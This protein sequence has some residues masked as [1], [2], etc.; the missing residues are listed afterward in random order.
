MRGGG[1]VVRGCVMLSAQAP[2]SAAGFSSCQAIWAFLFVLLAVF[3][4]SSSEQ[5][6][7]TNALM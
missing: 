3:D 5:M 1:E 2:Y 6:G 4:M 7:E